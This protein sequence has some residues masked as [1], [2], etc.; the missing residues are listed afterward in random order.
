MIVT[1]YNYG[2]FLDAVL[3]CLRAQ[4]WRDFEVI[5]I[6]DGSSDSE[7]VAKIG[8]LR[9]RQTEKFT[10]L[11]QSNQGVIAARNHAIA[12]AKGRYLFPLDADDT[13]APTFL[14]KCLLFL[15][16]APE[17]FFVY[18][19]THS[20]GEKDFVWE[21]RDSDPLAALEENRMG[22]AVFRKSAFDQVGGYNPVMKAGYEDW[23]LCVNLV[24]HGY[25]GRVIREPLYNYYVKSGARNYHAIKKHES[26]KA[27]INQLHREVIE[28]RKR[29]LTALAQQVYRVENPLVNFKKMEGALV[30]ECL[31]LDFY[32]EDTGA[33]R[34]NHAELFPKVVTFASQGR[35]LVLLLLSGSWNDFW[36]HRR[37]KNLLVYYP[38]HY[39][40]DARAQGFYD[41]LELC[42]RPRFLSLSRFL[43]LS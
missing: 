1:C 12:L 36:L 27:V 5:L 29:Y 16:S 9:K 19:W 3:A 2:C 14:E 26:L 28:S 11:Q 37:G 23:E 18:T 22:C 21:T 8:E 17:H 24:A 43:E 38:E 20:T 35:G 6:D 13:I 15:E 7:T 32:N 40:P 30:S 42:Y 4:T 39:H 31:V 41:Y 25:V 34:L 10:V 33:S